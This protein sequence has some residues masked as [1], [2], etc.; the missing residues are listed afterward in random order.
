MI[1]N[2]GIFSRVV[3]LLLVLVFAQE[4]HSQLRQQQD[5]GVGLSIGEPTG[6][7]ARYNL[8]PVCAFDLGLSWS[9]INGGAFHVHGDY[10]YSILRVFDIEYRPVDLYFGLG[11]RAKFS[12]DLLLGARLPV[13]LSYTL[14]SMPLE[15]F[16]E[17]AGI[18]DLSPS[19]DFSFNGLIGARYYF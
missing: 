7:S 4:S 1:K 2:K 10:L 14:A 18:F 6:L 11:A 12:N 9:F 3:L 15:L 8:D 19:T 5:F 13:G 16:V 17:L